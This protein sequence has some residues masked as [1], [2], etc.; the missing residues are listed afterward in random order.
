V[1][2]ETLR[3]HNIIR[4]V[5]AEPCIVDDIPHFKVHVGQHEVAQI[6]ATELEAFHL[7]NIITA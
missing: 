4:G 5:V 6:P 7:S 3:V 1:E 2:Y